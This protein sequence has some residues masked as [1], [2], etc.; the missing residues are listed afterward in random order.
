[1]QKKP[2]KYPRLQDY[3]SLKIPVTE[4]ADTKVNASGLQ[5][6]VSTVA[7]SHG[8]F[9]CNRPVLQRRRM[10]LSCTSPTNTTTLPDDVSPSSLPSPQHYTTPTPASLL[11]HSHFSLH[12]SLSFAITSVLSTASVIS[13]LSF[14]HHHHSIPPLFFLSLTA[15]TFLTSSFPPLP[16]SL[17]L[18][19]VISLTTLPSSPINSSPIW[20]SSSFSTKNFF[21]PYITSRTF[22]LRHILLIPHL[23]PPSLLLPNPTSPP[24]SPVSSPRQ[25]LTEFLAQR[26]EDNVAYFSFN[27]L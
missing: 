5:E 27:T 15:P 25:V 23:L 18:S 8:C 20:T 21:P 10:L 24:P 26:V 11:P 3:D 17:R 9:L 22:S 4:A 19:S 13:R 6:L 2:Q 7:V 12:L 1:M 14:L 16:D